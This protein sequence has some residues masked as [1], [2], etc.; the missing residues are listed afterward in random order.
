MKRFL[1]SA[2][3]GFSMLFGQAASDSA[4][5]EPPK[6]NGFYGGIFTGYATIDE[7][8]SDNVFGPQN[9]DLEGFI[10]G[11]VVGYNWSNGRLLLGAE[12]DGA[13][14]DVGDTVTG[15]A[16][17]AGG[18]CQIDWNSLI[19]VRG[20][21]GWIFGDEQE[22]ALYVTGGYAAS[23]IDVT[24]AGVGPPVN[25]FTLRG[26]TIGGGGE[27]YLFDTNWIST[28]IEYLFIDMGN[29]RDY[30]LGSVDT[31]TFEG[32]GHVVKFGLNIHF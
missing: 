12:V 9:F 28:K 31:A 18:I 5:A 16:G 17:A 29:S 23:H 11:L 22:Y 14:L 25:E 6:W 32:E 3:I 15:C 20:R 24:G 4:T 19:T 1:I 30:L 27:A 13:I 8:W 2:A 21:I 10:N 7:E 26:Y